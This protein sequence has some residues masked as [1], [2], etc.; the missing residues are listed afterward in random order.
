MNTLISPA[1]LSRIILV[2]ILNVFVG[3]ALFLAEW[4]DEVALIG[5]ISY[6]CW[7][8]TLLSHI[9]ILIRQLKNYKSRRPIIKAA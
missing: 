5:I 3:I 8:F 7:G 4:D 6:A 1:Y 9:R 2:L